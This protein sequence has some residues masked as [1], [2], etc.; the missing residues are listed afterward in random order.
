M[1]DAAQPQKYEKNKV[2]FKEGEAAPNFFVLMSG[3]LG[4]FRQRKFV[5]SI[6]GRGIF[7]GEMGSL[8]GSKRSATV[9]TLEPASLLPIPGSTDKIFLHHAQIG[10][11]LMASLRHRLSETYDQAEKLWE[12]V[13]EKIIDV[14]VYE[15]STKTAMRK[16]MTF[17]EL[18][19][20]KSKVKVMVVNEFHAD[21]FEY[22][23]IQVL[24]KKLDVEVEFERNMKE[25]FPRFK[26]V[27][28]KHM[29]D[30]WKKRLPEDTTEK[31]RHCIDLAVGLN[32]LTDFLTSFGTHGDQTGAEETDM[33]ESAIDFTKR[34]AILKSIAQEVLTPKEGIEKMKTINRDIDVEIE[35][36]DRR[37]QKTGR[38]FGFGEFAKKTG[39]G[40]PYIDR[41]RSE[42][43]T[44]CMKT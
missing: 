2:V 36:G 16:T 34:A 1:A 14:I 15:A 30:L 28:L 4:V 19:L 32:D 24:V 43:W 39:I 5:K 27:S 18:E 29:K 22:A 6:S 3:K 21:D 13:V 35:E 44:V 23:K 17:G 9:I 10:D 11:K 25:K 33:L 26:Y 8:L 41:L 12:H 38:V 7:V 37:Q 40:S 20:E 42:F 31:L